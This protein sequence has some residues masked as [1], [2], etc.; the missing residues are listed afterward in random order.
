[1]NV[2]VS[3]SEKRCL[4]SVD[5]PTSGR[6]PPKVVQEIVRAR[7]S[8]L[9][10]CYE[11]G[12]GRNPD[13]QGRIVT[14]FVIEHDGTVPWAVI[15]YADLPDRL[16]LDCVASEFPHMLFP[17]PVGGIVIVVYPIMFAPTPRSPVTP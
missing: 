7:F 8:V 2:R 4:A 6:L 14:R 11:A 12:L 16:V 10:R 17:P 3:K 13:L 15:D 9:Q 5:N 1:M